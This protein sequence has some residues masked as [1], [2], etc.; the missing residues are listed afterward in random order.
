MDLRVVVGNIENVSFLCIIHENI[1][2]W[3]IREEGLSL[4]CWGLSGSPG[5]ACKTS[6]NISTVV[7]K[8]KR[9][10]RSFILESPS[11]GRCCWPP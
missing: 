10:Q 5:F 7:T 9:S 11:P 1:F 4:V 6:S 8:A 2:K 3:D